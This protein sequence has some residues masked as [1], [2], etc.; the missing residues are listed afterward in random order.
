MLT[1]SRGSAAVPCSLQMLSHMMLRGCDSRDVIAVSMGF[2]CPT[3]GANRG[4]GV[5]P[6]GGPGSGLHG[7]PKRCSAA[8]TAQGVVGG[9][10]S[11]R[12]KGVTPA[13]CRGRDDG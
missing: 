4:A 11:S 2:G 3:R 13:V 8:E 10:A 1:R 9:L 5:D 6:V 7:S 12:W